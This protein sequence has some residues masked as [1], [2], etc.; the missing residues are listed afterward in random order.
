LRRRVENFNLFLGPGGLATPDD[1]EALEACQEGF[2]ADP[3]AYSDISRGMHRD[4]ATVDELQMRAFWREWQ[5][6]VL[7]AGHATHDEGRKPAPVAS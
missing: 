2:Q 5:A 7:G 1:I 3:A 6:N 4:A